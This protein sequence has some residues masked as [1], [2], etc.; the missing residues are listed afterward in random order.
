MKVAA[1]LPFLVALA[2]ANPIA[3]PEPNP[4]PVAVAEPI[5]F[6]DALDFNVEEAI[7]LSKRQS[8]LRT[9]NNEFERFGCRDV[10]LF[11]ARGTGEP[12]NMVCNS[13]PTLH[14]NF[15]WELN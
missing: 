14:F 15:G 11:F 8:A 10:I 7:E 5:P 6:D 13:A 3:I 2:V 4:E 9:T 12:G 1:F